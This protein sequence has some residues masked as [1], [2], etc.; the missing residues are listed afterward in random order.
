MTANERYEKAWDSFLVNLTDGLDGLVSVPV[1][2][3][4]GVFMII[5]YVSGHM[6]FATSKSKIIFRQINKN[7]T[8]KTEL[9]PFFA[10]SDYPDPCREEQRNY[11]LCS[12]QGR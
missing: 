1:M 7:A 11:R 9:S 5:A 8:F 10:K 3:V 2:I 6:A 4:A 12:Y